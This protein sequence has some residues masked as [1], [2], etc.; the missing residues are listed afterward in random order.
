[1]RRLLAA[2]VLL[3]ALAAAPA[4]G[5]W[6]KLTGDTLQNIVDPSVVVLP[7]TGTELIAYDE[8]QAGNLK[9]IRNGS[10]QTLASGLPFVGDAQIV[11]AG[12]TL[13][14]Y[15]GEG[16][17]V[18]PYG[19]TDGG[20]TW[21]AG[22]PL[23]GT[24]TGDVQAAAFLPAGPIFS[25]DGTGFIDVFNGLTG[26]LSVNAFPFC[27]GYAESLAVDSAGYAQIAFWSNSTGQSGY[28]YGPI[29]GPYVNLTGG[30]ESLANDARVPLV[31]DALGDT[32]LGWQT[33]YP[34]ANA[35]IVNTY[36]GG[37][38]VHSVRFAHSFK[39]P[40]PHMALSVDA[41]GRL[42][43]L[44]TQDG[45]VWAARS[46]THGASFGAAVHL[47]APG[48]VYQL[49]GGA[50]PNGAVDAVVNT[51]SN[52]QDQR[53]LPGL[54]VKVTKVAARVLDDGFPVAGATVRGGGKT[55]KT[56]AAGT[57]SLAGVRRHAA[58]AVAAAG[59]TPTGFRAP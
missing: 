58:L 55:L 14:L 9:V 59:Y 4:A 11:V 12:S 15:A 49:E 29:G 19:S 40:D 48:S 25:Q 45:A 35:Y 8:P 23:P 42:W 34:D 6:T 46:R 22:K 43:A 50:L 20:A 17:G 38:Q 16:T 57:V 36:H 3:L 32:F 1:V 51:G 2:G 37:K 31:A 54:T 10:T 33:G 44:W 24:R 39:Q 30:K 13:F 21:V 47:E 52:L 41:A 27:C 7:A 28:L 26:G 56:N 18:V 5:A 53:L